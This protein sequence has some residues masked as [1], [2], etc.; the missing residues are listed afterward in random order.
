M[1]RSLARRGVAVA[2]AAALATSGCSTVN[3]WFAPGKQAGQPGFVGG[4]IGAVVADE[5][6]AALI[7]RQTLASGGDAADA[8][9][10]MAYTLAVTLPSRAS[11]GAGGGCLAFMAS[12]KATGGGVPQAVL[13]PSRPG[14]GAQG[15]VT[16]DR[17]AAVPMLARGMY[18]LHANF[19]KL[20][21]AELIV[22]AE[23]LAQFGPPVSDALEHDLQVVA[24]PLAGDPDAREVF[25]RSG[26]PLPV[27]AA[28]VQPALAATLARIR[29]AGVGALYEGPGGRR[30]AEAADRAGGGITPEAMRAAIPTFSGA[31][32]EPGRGNDSVAFLPLDGGAAARLW[33]ESGGNAAAMQ[34]PP[35]LRPASTTFGALDRAGNAVVCTVSLNNLFGTGRMATGTGVVLAASPGTAPAPLLSAAIAYN[36]ALPGFRALVGGTGQQ[37]AA[38][39]VAAGMGQLL[40]DRSVPARPQPGSVPDPGRADMISCT[41][42]VP[43]SPESCGWAVDPR[44]QGLALGGG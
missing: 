7:G 8:A 10:A 35:G 43:G 6:Q 24:G 9:E 3:S 19:G 36:P 15:G 27:G 42:Y 17:P 38:V 22:P 23:R 33:R 1:A 14:G 12:K 40:E 18:V 11:L 16:G 41:R 5:P 29:I 30:F 4:F 31:I 34:M 25:F 44:G 26:R 21:E 13:F 20:S 39:A 28:L 32:V 37:G 2:C